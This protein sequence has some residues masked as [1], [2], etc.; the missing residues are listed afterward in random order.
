MIPSPTRSM[1]A[2]RLSRR[3]MSSTPSSAKERRSTDLEVKSMLLI[4]IDFIEVEDLYYTQQNIITEG[5]SDRLII[6]VL[7]SEERAFKPFVNPCMHYIHDIFPTQ[8]NLS[9]TFP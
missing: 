3:W 4:S 7:C 2:E 1:P 9:N 6:S 5:N 8:F